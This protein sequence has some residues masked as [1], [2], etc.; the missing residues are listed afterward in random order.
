MVQGLSWSFVPHPTQAE[1]E[2]LQRT[3]S[4][5]AESV[6]KGKAAKRGDT[7]LPMTKDKKATSLPVP[8]AAVK[9]KVATKAPAI[10]AL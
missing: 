5:D 10:R 2:V 9:I 6:G 8:S 7:T 3:A 4:H 1:L